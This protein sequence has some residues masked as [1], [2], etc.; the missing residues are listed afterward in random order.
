MASKKE[1]RRLRQKQKRQKDEKKARAFRESIQSEKRPRFLSN[2]ADRTGKNPCWQF[3]LLDWAHPEWGWK[4]ISAEEWSKIAEKL[5]HFE[6]MTWG[7]IEGGDTGSHLVEVG[8]CPNPETPKRLG[9]LNLDDV[10][11]L[12]SLRLSGA[13]RIFGILNGDTLKLLWY[14]PHHTVWPTRK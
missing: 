2:P 1:A 8:D 11:T 10:D 6:T 13:K 12:F 7:E 4:N 14:D 3:N 5:G 9:A